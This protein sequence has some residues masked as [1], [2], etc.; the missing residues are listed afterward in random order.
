MVLSGSANQ[1]EVDHRRLREIR[2]ILEYA[3]NQHQIEKNYEETLQAYQDVLLIYQNLAEDPKTNVEIRE[4]LF[5]HAKKWLD[6][7]MDLK[8]V[9]HAQHRNKKKQESEPIQETN[10]QMDYPELVDTFLDSENASHLTKK[11]KDKIKTMVCILNVS[12]PTV[13]LADI[14]G[15][16]EAKRH[17]IETILYSLQDAELKKFRDGQPMGCIFYG[18]PG[19]GKTFLA[20][21]IANEA[22]CTF[23]E[24]STTQI[25]DKYHGESA[26]NV[27]AIFHLA[28]ILQPTIIFIDEIESMMPDRSD[29][30]AVN[31]AKVMSKFLTE[32]QGN[33]G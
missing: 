9:I 21:A 33:A 30:S 12:K 17:A 1:T 32:M 19:T 8:N 18:Q 27:E 6:K 29:S 31:S 13:K 4:Q 22:Q 14:L 15:A 26:A 5:P 25:D 10:V 24:V 23:M 7:V 28:R 16:E 2:A 11:I 3:E 20:K